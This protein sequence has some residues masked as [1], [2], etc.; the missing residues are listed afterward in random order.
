MLSILN[1]FPLYEVFVVYFLSIEILAGYKDSCITWQDYERMY[2]ELV[3]S[4]NPTAGINANAF[5][6]VCLPCTE[7]SPMQCHHRITTEYIASQFPD[8]EIVHI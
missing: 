5:Y 4:R 3:V 2:R 1:V 6:H 7:K 8:I